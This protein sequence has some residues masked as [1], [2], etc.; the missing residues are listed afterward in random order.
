[1]ATTPTATPSAAPSAAPSTSSSAPSTAPVT[2]SVPSTPTPVSTPVAAPPTTTAPPAEATAPATASKPQPKQD[3]YPGDPQAF[4]DALHAWEKEDGNEVKIPGAEDETIAPKVETEAKKEE[5][6]EAKVETEATKDET[7]EK[8]WAPE[9]DNFTPEVV[10][11]WGKKYPELE[12]AWASHPELKRQMH[13]MGRINAKAA[14]L[15]KIFPNAQAGEFAAKTANEFVDLRQVFTTAGE[16]PTTIGGA[17]SKLAQQF[18][19]RDK[20]GKP[21]M[22]ADGK[23]QFFEEFEHLNNFVVDNWLDSDIAEL[24]AKVKAGTA[25]DDDEDALQNAEFLRERKKASGKKASGK[26]A[27]P[28]LSKLP[29]EL[30]KWHEDKQAEIDAELEKLGLQ[31]KEQSGAEKTA[32]KVAADRRV[33]KAIGGAV[34][35]KLKG[36]IDEKEANGIFIPSYIKGQKDPATGIPMFAKNIIDEF[37]A[38]CDSI[39]YV[40]DHIGQLRALP[41]SPDAEKQRVDYGNKLVDEFLFDIIDSEVRKVQTN[42]IDDQKRRR[43]QQKE[44]GRLASVEPAGGASPFSQG[45]TGQDA[46]ARAVEWVDKNKPDLDRRDRTVAILQKRNELERG[47]R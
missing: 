43:E 21:V 32:A 14:P 20:D 29:P 37:N 8:P 1:M 5:T 3:E 10:N 7:E 27:G 13:A 12:A 16:D 9:P 36:Y 23:E 24:A 34:G 28:D 18:M 47:A 45:S 2:T 11:E 4:L 40:R 31:K 17:Y 30:K 44:R 25:T 15:L 22:G 46:Y 39:A 6:T 19:V 38:K 41:L 42:H 26:P 35:K 33:G